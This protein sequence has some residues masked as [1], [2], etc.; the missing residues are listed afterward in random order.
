MR[1]AGYILQLKTQTAMRFGD[2]RNLCSAEAIS[3]R[4]P[5]KFHKHMLQDH[6][7]CRSQW[8]VS[9]SIIQDH[10]NFILSLRLIEPF[11]DAALEV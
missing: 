8:K 3:M 2:V 10:I 7:H 4:R 11:S 5:H 6:R 9:Y 1:N